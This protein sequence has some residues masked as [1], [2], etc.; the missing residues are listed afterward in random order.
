M[1]RHKLP[2]MA[3]SAGRSVCLSVAAIGLLAIFA[4]IA[5]SPAIADETR[6]AV[7]A[8]FTV[9]AQEIAQAFTRETGHTAILSYGSSGQVFTQV[10]HGAPYDMW[11]SADA[12]RPKAAEAQG[13]A[14]KGSRFTYA[15]GRLV[16]WSATP[17]FV[18]PQGRVLA[19]GGFTHLA[20]ADPG[21][22]PYGLAAMQTLEHLSLRRKLEP[23]IVRGTSITQTYDFVRTG[24]AELGF[25]A[26]SQVIDDHTGSRWLVPPEDYARIDQQAVLLKIGETNPAATA[27]LKFLRSDKARMIIR[28]Y[29]YEL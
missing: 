23:L 25:V 14:V 22:A 3:R 19:H 7:A 27:F 24:S 1:A 16:L 17:G 2:P 29:G 8:N 15:Y 13:F 18:D 20:I 9:P 26:L 4:A 28:R 12:E 21:A 5:A 10:A 6:V 11:L